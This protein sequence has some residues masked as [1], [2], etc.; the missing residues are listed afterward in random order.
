MKRSSWMRGAFALCALAGSSGTVAAAT[1]PACDQAVTAYE[2]KFKTRSDDA[3]LAAAKALDAQCSG[4]DAARARALSRQGVVFY[5]RK[6]F[7]GAIAAFQGAAKLNP[8]D[9]SLQMNICG[10]E[11][12]AGRHEDAIAACV[13]GLDP[14]RPRTDRKRSTKTCS[15]S[16]STWPSPRCAARRACS[17]R[18]V[19]EMFDT[20]RKASR[21]CLGLSIGRR[22]GLGLRQGFRQGPGS[23]QESCDLGWQPSCE[24]VAYTE[25]CMCKTRQ[26]G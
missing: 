13:A 2:A 24:Q 6:D 21:E 4:S 18:T 11:T 1:T 23:L 17:D 7:A 26:P 20:F 8:T 9:A 16:V 15:S 22:L 5:R 10:A 14:P 12:E 19:F 3:T 25:S